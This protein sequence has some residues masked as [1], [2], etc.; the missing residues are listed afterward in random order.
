MIRIKPRRC[1]YGGGKGYTCQ[2]LPQLQEWMFDESRAFVSQMTAE[3][4]KLPLRVKGMVYTEE[5]I[6]MGW[7]EFGPH[8]EVPELTCRSNTDPASDT[9]DVSVWGETGIP[10]EVGNATAYP[11]YGGSSGC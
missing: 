9:T 3:F 10:V 4:N 7:S 11:V 2:R 5:T 8:P 1:G 6:D